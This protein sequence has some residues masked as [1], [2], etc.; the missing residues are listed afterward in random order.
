[1]RLE[2]ATCGL[3]SWRS[4][5]RIWPFGK[6]ER[7]NSWMVEYIFHSVYC[8]LLINQSILIAFNSKAISIEYEWLYRDWLTDLNTEFKSNSRTTNTNEILM[9][10]NPKLISSLKSVEL[11]RTMAQNPEEISN[12]TM[13]SKKINL[14]K[15]SII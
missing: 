6:K 13:N 5:S 15:F 14:L 1:M 12:L 7:G 3:E 11:K 8:V 9:M 4:T 2:L 10:F